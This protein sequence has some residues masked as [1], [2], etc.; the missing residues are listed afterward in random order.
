MTTLEKV[1]L[2][3]QVLE[4][5]IAQLRHA[6]RH[7]GAAITA[8][9][10]IPEIAEHVL[11]MDPARVKTMWEDI[12]TIDK[13]KNILWCRRWESCPA[14]T[15]EELLSYGID[16]Q[17]LTADHY[18]WA[19]V[20]ITKTG[21]EILTCGGDYY[22]QYKTVYTTQEQTLAETALTLGTAPEGLGLEGE[23][24]MLLEGV[25]LAP[26]DIY[27]MN[28]EAYQYRIEMTQLDGFVCYGKS[29]QTIF[30]DMSTLELWGLE[31]KAILRFTHDREAPVTLASVSI[32]RQTKSIERSGNTDLLKNVLEA[33]P[34]AWLAETFTA[35]LTKQWDTYTENGTEYFVIPCELPTNIKQLVR[36]DVGLVNAEESLYLHEEQGTARIITEYAGMLGFPMDIWYV[37][38]NSDLQSAPRGLLIPK[39]LYRKYIKPVGDIVYGWQDMHIRELKITYNNIV[40]GM[41]R[42]RL[43]GDSF[44]EEYIVSTQD[45]TQNFEGTWKE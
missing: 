31:D 40:S 33:E 13:V 16:D 36:L 23:G 21:T 8:K 41:Q 3:A 34:A 29:S 22:Q 14:L 9:A 27:L 38:D 10:D 45:F 35:D 25:T 24:Y 1:N 26:G 39:K 44:G 15:T 7:N 20:R 17:R 19:V 43:V 37:Y 18:N 30:G 32:E 28:L 5:T 4:Q 12:N 42:L 11:D 6:V 2:K